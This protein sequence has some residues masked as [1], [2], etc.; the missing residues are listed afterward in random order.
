MQWLVQPGEWQ[1]ASPAGD[2]HALVA[3]VVAPGF[4]FADFELYAGEA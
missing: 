2:Q 3:C 1:R 4:D